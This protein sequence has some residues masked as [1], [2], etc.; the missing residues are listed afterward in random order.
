MPHIP[1]L[2]IFCLNS[3]NSARWLPFLIRELKNRVFGLGFLFLEKTI[4]LPR[5]HEKEFFNVLFKNT[6]RDGI[7]ASRYQAAASRV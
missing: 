4:T 2:E 3:I 6:N 7:G 5:A 1:M